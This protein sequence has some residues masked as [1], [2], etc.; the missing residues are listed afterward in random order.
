ME[1]TVSVSQDR[2]ALFFDDRE[3]KQGVVVPIY[4]GELQAI[5]VNNLGEFFGK[6]LGNGDLPKQVKSQEKIELT[7]EA[8]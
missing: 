8:H 4:F 2:V 6:K 5:G 1:L 7:E 3:R